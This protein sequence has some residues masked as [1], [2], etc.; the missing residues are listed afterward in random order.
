MPITIE[1]PSPGDSV[2]PTFTAWGHVPPR[3]QG[4]PGDP[5]AVVTTATLKVT[6]QANAIAT[7]PCTVTTAQ[8]GRLVWSATFTTV[9]VNPAGYTLTATRTIGMN[10]ISASLQNLK[11]DANAPP[12]P[13]PPPASS[14]SGT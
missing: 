10:V 12:L 8:D 7:V 5:V 9:P 11:I 13:L 3:N 4:G 14:G 2:K 1:E 6:G